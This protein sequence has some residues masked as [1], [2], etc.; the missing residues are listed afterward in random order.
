M[1]K[2]K[3]YDNLLSS[4]EYF[5]ADIGKN[6]SIWLLPKPISGVI[7]YFLIKLKIEC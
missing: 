1:K 4:L 3:I 5:D 7:I 6:R 2:T